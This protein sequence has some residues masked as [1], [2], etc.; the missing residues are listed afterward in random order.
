VKRALLLSVAS[1]ALA[2][3]GMSQQ[4]SR[5]HE[6]ASAARKHV[7]VNG[8]PLPANELIVKDGITYVDASALAQALGAS[9]QSEEAGLLIR[10]D[11]PACDCDKATPV[12]EGEHF[13]EQFRSDVA[14]VP[15]E[16]ESLRAVVLKKEKVPLGPR[17]DDIDH[18]LS[19]STVHVQTDADMAVYYALSYANNALAIAYYKE[20]RGVASDEAQKNLLDSMM[21]S[22]E[23]K[24][25]LMKGTLLPG[26]SCSV[27]KRMESQLAPKPA[28]S[29]E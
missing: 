4:P 18:Q 8:K 12:V 26:G 3:P 19:L 9:V 25:A 17:F 22:M 29:P 20:S 27:F 14:R 10:A 7:F 24:F 1:L 23:S 13:S 21:C 15:D 28:E 16:I 5:S 2:S 6:S 11:Q